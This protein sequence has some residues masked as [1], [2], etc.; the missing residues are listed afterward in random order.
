MLGDV[1]GGVT[2]SIRDELRL[3]GIKYSLRPDL[4]LQ[5][6][7]CALMRV[8]IESCFLKFIIKFRITADIDHRFHA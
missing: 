5:L 8:H 3:L 2:G 6:I 7:E 1:W 4:L